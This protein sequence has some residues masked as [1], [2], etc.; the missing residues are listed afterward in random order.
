MQRGLAVHRIDERHVVNTRGQLRKQIAHPQSRLAMLSELPMA[1]LTIARLRRKELQ[2]AIGVKRLPGT[3]FKFRLVIKRIDLTHAA[4]AEDLNHTLCLRCMMRLSSPF[5]SQHRRQRKPAESTAGGLQK[6]SS[7]MS[8]AHLSIDINELIGV[9]ERPAKANSPCSLHKV[10]RET[11]FT[12]V[13]RLPNANSKARLI[14]ACS[15]YTRLFLDAFGQVLCLPA[16]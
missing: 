13:G 4:G 12:S 5:A 6:I 15:V 8:S 2:L 3:F 1:A 11:I 10:L 7:R 16:A 9:E 14:C